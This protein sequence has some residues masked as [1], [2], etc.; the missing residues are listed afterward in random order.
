MTTGPGIVVVLLPPGGM[1]DDDDDDDD[2]DRG[3]PSSR[4]HSR[5]TRGRE[6]VLARWQATAKAGL[7]SL[8][9]TT[10]GR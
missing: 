8:R 4:A 5:T 10:V 1:D 2:D 7:C 6:A 9:S 3:A